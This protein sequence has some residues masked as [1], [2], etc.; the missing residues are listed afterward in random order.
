MHDRLKKA[1]RLIDNR[2]GSNELSDLN[3]IPKMNAGTLIDGHLEAQ[4]SS[5]PL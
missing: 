4:T 1:N 5:R 2:N 3:F